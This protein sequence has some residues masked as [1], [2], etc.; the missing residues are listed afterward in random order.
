MSMKRIRVLHVDDNADARTLLS[1]LLKT[2]AD[3]EEV[4]CR[5]DTEGLEEVIRE[6]APD[7]LL[8]DLTMH[9]RDPIE[10]IQGVREAYPALRIVVLSGSRNPALLERAR[11]A[12]ASQ[13]ALKA[14]DLTETLAAIRGDSR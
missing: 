14:A 10:A 8:I 13:L 9:G 6:T 12:G 2:E 3:L 7:V 5:S 4:G 1:F 11:K